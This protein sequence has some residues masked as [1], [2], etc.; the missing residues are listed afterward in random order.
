MSD[1]IKHQDCRITITHGLDEQGD[2]IFN[3]DLDGD[4]PYVYKK[5]LRRNHDQHRHPRS[6]PARPH[7]D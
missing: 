2:M 3:V 4:M 5:C 7:Q 1:R 6:P